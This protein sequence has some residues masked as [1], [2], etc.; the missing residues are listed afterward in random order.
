M[1]I[2]GIVSCA[3]SVGNFKSVTSINLQVAFYLFADDTGLFYANDNLCTLQSVVNI[4][5][6]N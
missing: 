4:K 1:N 3:A 5:L 6:H 2:V